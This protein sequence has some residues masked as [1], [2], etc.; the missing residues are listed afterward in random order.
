MVFT[1]EAHAVTS[2]DKSTFGFI[3]LLT[4][5]V[6]ESGA[7]NWGQMQAPGQTSFNVLD[8]PFEWNT[9][10]RIGVGHEFS[11]ASYDLVLAYSHYQTKA[12]NQA[13]GVIFSSFV[14]NYFANNTNGANFGPTYNTANIRWQFFY[15]TIDLNLGRHFKLDPVL[16]VHPYVG[17][18]AASINQKIYT[19][20]LN[21]TT[22]TT[23]TAATEN[24]KN[25]FLGVGPV[26]GVDTTWAIYSG[27]R[28]SFSLIGNIA[29]G[30]LCGHW[31]FDDVYSN[32]TP[33]SITTN[34]DSVNGASPLVDGLLSLQWS[35]QFATFD[36]SVRL[37]YEAQVWFNQVQFYSLNMGRINRPTWLQGGDLEFRLNF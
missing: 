14:S 9:G 28:Q 30:L 37:G 10:F 5:Q 20:W 27:T 12:F 11:Q 25:D 29:G 7:D 3:D 1:A 33:V 21:P 13:S 35:S 31:H 2:G 24:L 16:Q 6:R 15:N 19:N 4:W 18:K 23:F 26:I 17:L 8:A 34:L 22:P 32:N 36:I